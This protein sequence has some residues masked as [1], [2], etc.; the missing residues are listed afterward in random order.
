MPVHSGDLDQRLSRISTQWS[1]VFQAHDGETAVVSSAQRQL[2]ERYSCAVY[3]YLLGAVRDP[4]TAEELAQEFALRFVRGDFRRA[5]PE[6]GR[7]RD[8]LKTAVIHLVTD[9][10]R[11]RQVAPVQLASQAPEVVAPAESI[12]AEPDFLANWREE[13]LQRT[14]KA[15]AQ[16]Q[17]DYHAILL[18]RVEN[19]EATSAQAAEELQARLQKPITAAAVRKAVQ[20][21]HGKFA[22]LLVDEVSASLDNP[23]PEAVTEE[24]R[25][26]DLLK[27]CQSALERRRNE[28]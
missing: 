17:P 18:H 6:R 14:W 7:F 9:Y 4:D 24:L 23:T 13:L 8:Y 26:L 10:H 16:A 2:M 27:Y 5:D 21:A 19:P 28:S 15:L 1:M 25:A 11:A 20:R 3:R 12:V 22:D